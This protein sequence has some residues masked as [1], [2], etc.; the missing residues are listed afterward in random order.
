MIAV[1][2]PWTIRNYLIFKKFVFIKSQAGLILWIGNNPN[3]TGC[4]FLSSGKRVDSTVPQERISRFS[5]MI[6]TDVYDE[7]GK[8]A[9]NYILA[10]PAKTI[11]NSAKKFY[12]FWTPFEK[13]PYNWRSPHNPGNFPLFRQIVWGITLFSGILGFIL[14]LKKGK[15]KIIILLPPILLSLTYSLFIIDNLRFRF[16]IEP[17]IIIFSAYLINIILNFSSKKFF[18]KNG[19]LSLLSDKK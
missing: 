5:T 19:E 12:F 11:T 14:S 3:A 16:T 18:I 15:D 9:I 7:L 8:E 1:I 13:K 2:L 10:N 4:L 17:Y 6:E